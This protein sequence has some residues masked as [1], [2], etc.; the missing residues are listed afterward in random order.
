MSE[1][2][3]AFEVDRAAAALPAGLIHDDEVI[4]LL[5]R[6]SLLYIPLSCLTGLSAIALITLLLAY[7]ARWQPAWISWSDTGAFALGIGLGAV[8]LGWQVLEWYSRV[9]VLTDRRVLRR[10]GVLRVAIFET[11]LRNIQH[12]SVFARVRERLFGLGSIGFATAGSDVFD[13]FWMM[14]RKPFDVHKTVVEAIERAR[15]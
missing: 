3:G 7:L 14:V 15:R 13:A 5:L 4:I 9:Y 8:R 6:P 2:T 10:M 11:A 1:A 12:T